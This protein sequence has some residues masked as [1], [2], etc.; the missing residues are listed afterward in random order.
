MDVIL[1]SV[2]VR[3]DSAMQ[4]L[5]YM[6]S[7]NLS[8]IDRSIYEFGNILED[9]SDIQNLDSFK[10]K[11]S[12]VCLEL[13]ELKNID[14]RFNSKFWI[15][16][17]FAHGWTQWIMLEIYSKSEILQPRKCSTGHLYLGYK[18]S[19]QLTFS[20]QVQFPQGTIISVL[21]H[22]CSRI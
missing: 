19:T 14:F 4:V 21:N 17:L 5:N 10:K 22:C 15:M 13:Y 9:I 7:Q 18:W 3:S 8:Q 16:I 12:N 11:L 2:P 1:W 20:E 6:W